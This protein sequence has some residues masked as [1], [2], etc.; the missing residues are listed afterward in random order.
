MVSVTEWLLLVWPTTV[1]L[2]EML[3]VDNVT[4]AVPVPVRAT[5]C[6]LLN[7]LSVNVSAPVAAPSPVGVNVTPT[8]QFPLAAMLAPQVLVAM[9]NGPL[10]TMLLMLSAALRRLV[11]VTE[12]AALVLPAATFPKL[13]LLGE[14][15]TG[16]TPDPLSGTLWLPA[17]SVMATLP[18]ALP[19]T[20]GEKVTEIVQLEPEAIGATVQLSVSANGPET[21]I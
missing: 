4:G 5:V 15:V 16:A 1:L 2:K 9:A 21:V 12:R 17:L 13:R 7:A 6:G 14:K 19:V 18:L 10:A 20:S 8:A 11:T 3:V